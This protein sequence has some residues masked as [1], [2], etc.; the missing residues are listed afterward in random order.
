MSNNVFSILG[1]MFYEPA[2]G[3][4]ALKD[5]SRAWFPL[6][7]MLSFVIGIF[8]WYFQ[9]VDFAWLT[10][11]MI[12]AQPDMKPEAREAF[13]KMMNKN[14]M[15]IM[16]IVGG[17]IMYPILYAAIALYFLIV[18]KATDSEI[19]FG[20]WFGFA[21]WV[22]VPGLLAFPLMAT[23]IMS[24]KGQIALEE[25]NMLSLNFLIFHFPAG[26]A[27]ASLLGSINLTTFWTIFLTFI[28]WR[29]WTK[30][31]VNSC[32]AISSAPFIV[33]YGLWI[34]KLVFFA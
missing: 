28:G 15:M 11:H 17:A 18:S 9:T 19:S 31:S 34:A 6:A 13:M 4:T 23:Q 29:T 21:G 22:S 16:T 10:E 27:W 14:T 33:V 26:T 2:A 24:G 30:C 3:F 5:K 7:L 1:Q 8:Y 25:L 20:K 32:I 12:S